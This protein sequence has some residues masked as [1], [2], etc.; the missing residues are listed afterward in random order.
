[1]DPSGLIRFAPTPFAVPY[2]E[3]PISFGQSEWPCQGRGTRGQRCQCSTNGVGAGQAPPSWCGW[4]VSPSYLPLYFP[5][6]SFVFFR[7]IVVVCFCVFS[8]NPKNHK[9]YKI[10]QKP[11]KHA[12]SFPACAFHFLHPGKIQKTKNQYMQKTKNTHFH[13]LHAHFVFLH[14]RKYRKK[15]KS[16]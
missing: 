12:F 1:M 16:K 2:P 9:N 6:L 11:Q 14:P 7:F 3:P 5:A 10:H 13:F 8:P 4:Q 15:I